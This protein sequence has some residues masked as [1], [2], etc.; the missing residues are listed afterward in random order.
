[1]TFRDAKE[2]FETAIELCQ[3]SDQEGDE[4]YAGLYMYMGD[5]RG[6]AYF[7]HRMTRQY[8]RFPY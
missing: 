6:I 8:L 3:L 5:E 1:M 4:N 7:K 2:A